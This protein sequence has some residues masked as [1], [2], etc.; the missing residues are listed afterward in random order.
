[1]SWDWWSPDAKAFECHGLDLDFIL[2]SLGSW[3]DPCHVSLLESVGATGV[4]GSSMVLN[5]SSCP[6]P[7]APSDQP[8]GNFIAVAL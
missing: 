7:R 8:G 4:P 6:Q 2:Q 5:V 1:M 3:C